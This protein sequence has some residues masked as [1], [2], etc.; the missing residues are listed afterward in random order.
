[1][2]VSVIFIDSIIDR[3]QTIT[4]DIVEEVIDGNTL[5]L[6]SGQY[7]RLIGINSD[8]EE[9]ADFIRYHTVGKTV[10]LEKDDSTVDQFGRLRRYV[11]LRNPTDTNCEVQIASY[12]LNALL[13]INGYASPIYFGRNRQLFSQLLLE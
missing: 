10:W 4:Q 8:S 7:V 13:I 3:T 11:W 2:L 1:M 9:A 12:Q 6:S 5:L